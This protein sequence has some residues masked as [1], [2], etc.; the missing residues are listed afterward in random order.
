MRYCLKHIILICFVL[1]ILQNAYAQYPYMYSTYPFIR[2]EEN[3]LIFP[4]DSSRML[5]FFQK[6]DD[7][8]FNGK[9]HIQI[10]H[11]GGSHVQADIF[12]GR[13]RERFSTFFPGNKGS[14]GLVFPYRIANTN[15]PYNY[16]ASYTGKWESCK[17]TQQNLSCELGITG[18]SATTKDTSSTISLS[19]STDYY[20]S[21]DFNTIRV[22]HKIDSNQFAI[23]PIGKDSNSYKTICYPTLGY[24]DIFLS[25]YCQSIV[26]GLKKTDSLQWG[27]TL[28]GLQLE[29][30]DPG[31]TYHAAGVN[32]AGTYSF[33]RC[34]LFTPQLR[35]LKPDLVIFGLGINDAA[36]KDFNAAS[37]EYNYKKLIDSVLAANPDAAILLLTN[38]DSFRKYK[39]KFYVNK[40]GE[41]VE[42]SML[43]V[44]KERNLGVWDFFS[45][46][47]GLGCMETWM[48]NGLGKT[49][50]VHFTTSGYKLM[51]D[52]LFEA[53]IK[54]YE[55][56]LIR[57]YTTDNSY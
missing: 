47:G 54:T 32:G 18:I 57:T 56:Y 10:L 22:F 27:Y 41:T 7:L 30:N 44:A 2:Y 49:D 53:I 35:I 9:G 29:N 3:Q 17:N 39:R 24:T 4:G 28:Y 25:E 16:V 38:N 31:I 33:L 42:Q 26:L 19:L 55:Q 13:T 23:I 51:G 14:R 45:I 6:L 50:R 11:I 12:T 8:I 48:K 20:Q 5:T 21:Y 15:N 40:N 46:M 36:S 37:F 1:S 34:A 43:R 52:L